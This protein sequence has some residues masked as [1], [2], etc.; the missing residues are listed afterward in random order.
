MINPN[1]LSLQIDRTGNGWIIRDSFGYSH[2]G[3]SQILTEMLVAR[4]P[5]QLV[6]LILLWAQMQTD[7]PVAK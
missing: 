2:D 6:E 5:S 7:E 3:R 4:T 1:R